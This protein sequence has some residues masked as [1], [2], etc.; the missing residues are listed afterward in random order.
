[1]TAAHI[2]GRRWLVLY[3]SSAVLAT[4]LAGCGGQGSDSTS[5]ATIGPS[6]AQVQVGNTINY[7]SFGTT[8]EV[9]C[10]NGKSLDVGGSNNTLT[11]LGTC[12]SVKIAGA[13]N[14]IVFDKIDEALAVYGLNNTVTIKAGDPKIDNRGQGNDVKKG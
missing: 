2:R 14:K 13:D 5:T 3:L 10:A 9:D 4:G 1:V 7:G 12:S 6:G 11:V 8:A